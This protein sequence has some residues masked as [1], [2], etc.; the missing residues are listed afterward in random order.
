MLDQDLQTSNIKTIISKYRK[1]R[2]KQPF[3][4]GM[5]LAITLG[6]YPSAYAQNDLTL[7]VSNQLEL[8]NQGNTAAQVY[9]AD[10]YY[11]GRNGFP[12]DDKLALKYYLLA[13]NKNHA[14]AQYILA[15]M[16]LEGEGT[17][18]NQ[19][20]AFKY[21]EKSAY[22]NLSQAQFALGLWYQD[23]DDFLKA[24]PQKAKYW[25]NKAAKNNSTQAQIELEE[26]I[27]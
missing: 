27:Q 15:T 21:L 4:I 3:Y 2:F 5:V 9:I 22:N 13:A 11:M 18:V 25:L 14:E 8:A 7:T 20:L 26:L 1:N 10:S 23:G 24:N 12:M 16:Y 6:N 17:T 19:Q